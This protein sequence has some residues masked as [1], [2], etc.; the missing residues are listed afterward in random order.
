[1]RRP[2]WFASGLVTLALAW[3]MLDAAKHAFYL[4]M[5]VH[6]SVVAVA[7]PLLAFSIAG[8]RWDPVRRVPW[9]F[10]AM[11]ASLIELVVVWA[12]H[13]PVLHLAARQTV[14][15]L[16]AEQGTFLFSGIYLWI[17]VFGG[18]PESRLDRGG[19]GVAAL[20]LTLMHMTL[21]GALLA[22]SPRPLYEHL[23]GHTGLSPLED[24]HLGG[25]IML[26]VGAVAYLAG[27]LWLS[28]ELLRSRGV[29]STE[30]V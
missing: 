3:A 24:Q 15:A 22:L 9:L 8:G 13:T 30:R 26:T 29:A 7:A 18:G 16:L 2:F 21:L 14:P 19:T 10:S 1:M 20:L 25:A 28:Y 17:S 4:H 12:W 6:M 5:I 23:H 11:V 27:G